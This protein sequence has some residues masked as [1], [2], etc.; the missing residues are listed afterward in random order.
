MPELSFGYV[1]EPPDAGEWKN[2]EPIYASPRLIDERQSFLYIFR[3]DD[4]EVLSFSEVANFYIWPERILCHL[5][6]TAYDYMV[7]LHF[8]G[9]VLSYWL[10]RQGIPALHASAVV[11]DGCAAA[12]LSSNKGGKSSL[13][14]SLMQLGYPLLTDDILPIERCGKSFKGRSGY[15]QM[16]MW[17]DQAEYF[18]GYYEPLEKVHPGLSKR[19]I[20][21]GI[22]GLGSFCYEAQ[23]LGC[24]YLPERREVDKVEITPFSLGEAI[25][26]LTN[27]SFLAGMVEAAG[28]QTSRFH[29]FAQLAQQIPVRRIV[30]PD[31]MEHLPMVRQAI[32]ED[33]SIDLS[34]RTTGA[35]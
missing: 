31:G 19:R 33:L 30:Y 22:D 26:A 21:V 23:S 15:P 14:A 20:P 29:L 10:E 7:E 4:Y 11:V 2:G 8:L 27:H 5:L 24:F 3:H 6:D 18:L 17:P 32:L 34:K 12:F 1:S 16:R 9:F 13:A 28:W 35:P 25:V